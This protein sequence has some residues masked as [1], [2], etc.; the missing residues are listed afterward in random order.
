VRD[1]VKLGFDSLI[2][3]LPAMTMNIAPKRRHTVQIFSSM[4]INKVVALAVR[5]DA[6]LL[7]H[8]L[9]HLSERMPKITVI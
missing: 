2:D 1:A 8:P 4:H 7:P 9:L 5:D 6:G 3:F